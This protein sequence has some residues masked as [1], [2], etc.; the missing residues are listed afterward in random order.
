MP[1]TDLALA[2][3]QK[4]SEFA[5]FDSWQ[6]ALTG[7]GGPSD[8]RVWARFK[9]GVVLPDDECAA[10]FHHEWLAALVCSVLPETAMGR[11]FELNIP[12]GDKLETRVQ[13]RLDELTAWP[14]LLEAAIWG[15]VFGAGAVYMGVDDGQDPS[16]PLNYDAARTLNYLAV[17]DK[18][19]LQVES[20]YVDPTE[21]KFGEPARYWMRRQ[22][23]G[24]GAATAGR[25]VLVH[26]SRMLVFGGAR[27]AERERLQNAGFDYSILQR[28]YDVLRDWGIGWGSAA[29]LLQTASQ[30]VYGVKNLTRILA[31]EQGE[32]EIVK[33]FRMIE[34]GRS[35]ARA[36]LIDADGE[37]FETKAVSFSGVPDML[38]R[39][40][41]QLA[42]ATR[43]PVTILMGQAPAG[44]SA[45]GESDLRTWEAECNKFRTDVLEPCLE[46]LV[47]VLLLEAGNE[48]EN[49]S[50]VWPPIATET[51]SQQAALRKLVA[52]TDA[53]YIT[54][55]VVLPEEVAQSR[56][57]QE[58]WSQETQ[59]NLDLRAELADLKD[60]QLLDAAKAGQ[61][62]DTSDTSVD[63]SSPDSGGEKVADT[64]LNGAQVSSLIEVI[65]AVVDGR[66]PRDTAVNVIA[67]A[68]NVSS[69]QADT[70][71]GSVGKGFKPE[72][73]APAPAPFGG[74]P[75]A[76]APEDTDAPPPK[77]PPP[78]PGAKLPK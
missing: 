35:L 30:A 41:N 71:L 45:T 62:V 57:A 6:N 69:A 67:L 60:D 44:L 34:M 66:M 31:S 32:Q 17:V 19:D 26:E 27:T 20:W 11:G 70:L 56:F 5:R 18:R 33:R 10:L 13:S 58:G 29:T 52:E 3:V 8:K 15:R 25:G 42:A 38:D 68:F 53:I 36:L 24:P 61:D 73:A 74:A 46:R 12:D 55:S 21:Q 40:S 76:P 49:W 54:Q 9:R 59:I 2:A 14:K 63:V 37:T 64:A 23:G 4:V 1:L 75:R 7:L 28:V 47:R 51:P 72:P 39:F 22:T 65:T 50:I 43:I 77:S 78:Q 16:L 48:P